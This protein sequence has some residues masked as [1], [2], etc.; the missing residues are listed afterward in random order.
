MA[1]KGRGVRGGEKGMG[2][3]SVGFPECLSRRAMTTPAGS[4]NGFGTVCWWGLSPA[5]DLQ[6]ESESHPRTTRGLTAVPSQHAQTLF[7]T[8]S[9]RVP[10]RGAQRPHGSTAGGA[11]RRPS[12]PGTSNPRMHRGSPPL[13]TQAQREACWIRSLAL[14]TTAGAALMASSPSP[15]SSCQVLL[16]TQTRRQMRRTRPLS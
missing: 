3:T 9:P 14:G 15:L 12:S 2:C 13:G 11:L 8:C 6:A 5:L 10:G 7:R 16:W 4:G 1:P